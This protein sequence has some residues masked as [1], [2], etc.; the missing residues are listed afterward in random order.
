MLARADL[1]A[2]SMAI[3]RQVDG[4]RQI[5]GV[6]GQ[7]LGQADRVQGSLFLFW[8]SRGSIAGSALRIGVGV[9]VDCEVGGQFGTSE[10]VASVPNVLT[11]S[12]ADSAG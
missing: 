9:C 2:G 3:E 1:R 10:T 5:I 7:C 12:S 6:G 11:H 4:P 8:M